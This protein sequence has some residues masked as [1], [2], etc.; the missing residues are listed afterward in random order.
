MNRESR[1]FGME[2]VDVRIRENRDILALAP[3]AAG[4][5]DGGTGGLDDPENHDDQDD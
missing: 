3:G 5:F 2:I 1:S 4:A